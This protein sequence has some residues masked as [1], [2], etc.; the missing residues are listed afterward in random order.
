LVDTVTRITYKKRTIQKYALTTA[1][2]PET[3]SAR[4]I[5]LPRFGANGVERGVGGVERK[6][7]PPANSDFGGVSGKRRRGLFLS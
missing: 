1:P 3:T 2:K 4:K 7:N 5:F 6:R